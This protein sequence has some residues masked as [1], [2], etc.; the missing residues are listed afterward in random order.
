MKLVMD[1]TRIYSAFVGASGF[2]FGQLFF[3][4]FSIA[5]TLAGV[6]GVLAGVISWPG[7]K[8]PRHPWLV[9][10]CCSAG[11]IGVALDAYGYYSKDHVPGNYYAWF[12]IGPFVICLLLIGYEALRRGKA[13]SN[14][15][16][17]PDRK[18]VR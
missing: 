17:A 15:K 5:S 4:D 1:A 18:T 13:T 6:S 14:M 10:L 9:P 12:L 2:L 11:L 16:D 3:G 7:F 8:M